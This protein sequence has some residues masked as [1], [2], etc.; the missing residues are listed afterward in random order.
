MCIGWR[1]I[2][3]SWKITRKK[4]IHPQTIISGFRKAVDIAYKTLEKHAIDNS[5]NPEKFREDLLNIA[6]TTLSSKILSTAKDHFA[7]LAVDAVLRLKG[8]TDLD[9]ISIIKKPG[10]SL[11]QSY[12][13][14][15]FILEKKFGISQPKKIENAKILIANTPM[16]TDKIKIYSAIIETSS[17]SQ[18]AEIEE[19]ERE[20]MY[21][22]CQKII[23]HGVNVFINRQLIYNLPEQYFTDRGV[24]TIEHADFSGVERLALVLGGEVVSTFDN[25]ELVKLGTA[26]CIEE[27]MIGEDKVLKF[28]GCGGGEACAIVLRGA[29]S[30]I[31]EEAERSLHDALCV[32]SQ[33]IKNSKTVWGAGSSEMLMAQ[34][35]DELASKTEG[36]EALAIEGFARALR[37][38]PTILADNAGFDTAE[39]ISKL[40]AQHSK[41]NHTFGINMD[42]GDISD[43]SVLKITESFKVKSQILISSTEAAEM[44]LRVDQIISSAPRERTKDPRYPGN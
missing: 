18:V 29:N 4:K 26:K 22:K 11:E 40:K 39:L 19:T 15:G 34:A 7:N 38:I 17:T 41:G 33:M 1:T 36:K 23:K 16:D 24:S 2:K 42:T 20:K 27:I 37:M 43:I 30:H 21:E 14:D 3:R 31:L 8:S 13:D 10:D 28:S 12:L 25:P 44:I 35:V 5:D 9:R 32:L 6:R